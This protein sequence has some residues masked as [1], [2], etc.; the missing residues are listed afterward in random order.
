MNNKL[1]KPTKTEII[2]I[3][4]LWHETKV[5]IADI[6]ILFNHLSSIDVSNICKD[7]DFTDITQEIKL[8][9]DYSNKLV[10]QGSIFPL[11]ETYVKEIY[12]FAH[13][14]KISNNIVCSIFNISPSTLER[15]KTKKS[16]LYKNILKNLKKPEISKEIEKEVRKVKKPAKSLKPKD[17]LIIINSYEKINNDEMRVADLTRMFDVTPDTIRRFL[18]MNGMEIHSKFSSI[19]LSDEEVLSIFDEAYAGEKTIK[20]VAEEHNVMPRTVSRI[21]HGKTHK[22]VLH[23][24]RY[25]ELLKYELKY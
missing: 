10:K 11:G 24:E 17:R 4:K 6:C 15:I 12:Y 23:R 25:E 18:R 21:L 2:R 13:Y 9:K 5:T 22:D 3:Y 1:I 16:K 7:R 20:R 19:K 14:D 8:D